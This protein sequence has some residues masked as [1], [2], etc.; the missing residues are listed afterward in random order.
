MTI[1]Y[2]QDIKQTESKI[3]NHSFK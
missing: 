2:S 1:F 3:K